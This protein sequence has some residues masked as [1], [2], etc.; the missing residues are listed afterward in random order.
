MS[1]TADVP[2]VSCSGV[3]VTADVPEMSCS[4]VSVTADVPEMTFVKAAGSLA[5]QAHRC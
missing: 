5:I 2:E 4:G 1:V 3:S